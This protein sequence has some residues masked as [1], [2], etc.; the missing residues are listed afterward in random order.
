MPATLTVV[1]EAKDEVVA[2]VAE[3]EIVALVAAMSIDVKI[4][5]TKVEWKEVV[6]G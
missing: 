4:K 1:I 3:T 2:E 5:T 6:E